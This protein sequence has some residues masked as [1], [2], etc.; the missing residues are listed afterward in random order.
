[1][2]SPVFCVTDSSSHFC[3]FPRFNNSVLTHKP[4]SVNLQKF[5]KKYIL[6]KKCVDKYTMEY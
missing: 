3:V 1:M 5:T 4:N 6:P 2:E